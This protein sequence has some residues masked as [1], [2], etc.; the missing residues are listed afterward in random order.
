MTEE[1]RAKTENMLCD[2][3]RSLVFVK[4]SE[5][6]QILRVKFKTA[7]HKFEGIKAV[8]PIFSHVYTHI[9]IHSRRACG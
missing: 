2:S 4:E 9:T 3:K 1:E 6:Y 8:G 5:T 7:L